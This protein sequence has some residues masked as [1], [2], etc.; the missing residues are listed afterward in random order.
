MLGDDSS[1]ARAGVA[2]Q[3]MMMN[4]EVDE[5]DRV[6]QRIMPLGKITMQLARVSVVF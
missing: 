3:A 5:T 1:Q 6:A 2:S 4:D